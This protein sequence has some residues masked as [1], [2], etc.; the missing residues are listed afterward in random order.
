MAGGINLYAYVG[1]D[2][3]GFV[4]PLVRIAEGEMDR[5]HLAAQEIL[6]EDA[7]LVQLSVVVPEARSQ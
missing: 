5:D 6:A 1:N 7:P 2:P 3:T 4:D